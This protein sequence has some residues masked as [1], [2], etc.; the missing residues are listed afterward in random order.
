MSLSSGLVSGN[1]DSSDESD[2]WSPDEL[3]DDEPDHENENETEATESDDRTTIQWF[4]VRSLSDTPDAPTL[5]TE[6]LQPG[7]PPLA[8]GNAVDSTS[9]PMNELTS[10][11][12][13]MAPPPSLGPTVVVDPT[14]HQPPSDTSSRKRRA[15][16]PS[17]SSCSGQ[18]RAARMSAPCQRHSADSSDD[19]DA[20]NRHF[21]P[22]SSSSGAGPSSDGSSSSSGA[23][24]SNAS[25]VPTCTSGRRMSVRR[26][27][28]TASARSRA[29]GPEGLLGFDS[30]DELVSWFL[31]KLKEFMHNL[32]EDT[33]L[34]RRPELRD[35]Y[36]ALLLADLPVWTR[37]R[38]VTTWEDATPSEVDQAFEASEEPELDQALN[39][40]MD[41]NRNGGMSEEAAMAEA[42]RASNAFAEADREVQAREDADLA[43]AMRDSR[44]D[45]EF[46]AAI[47]VIVWRAQ[48]EQMERHASNSD[49]S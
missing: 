11:V 6:P 7:A 9:M 13:D 40:N 34:H 42:I 44:E 36:R 21:W 5:A 2:G 28:R 33:P 35:Q 37:I 8:S 25:Q 43:A 24:P 27:T 38:L 18:P 17:P 32:P 10:T 22:T 30:D 16:D 41:E 3:S 20:D 19:D 15:S 48:I 45:A 12:V 49:S 1:Y 23:E 14:T 47:D 39:I 46:A 4:E 31:L 29:N 26:S